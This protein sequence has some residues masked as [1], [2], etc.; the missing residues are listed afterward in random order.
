MNANRH[1]CDEQGM[2]MVLCLMGLY[3]HAYGI[4]HALALYAMFLHAFLFT[5]FKP[6]LNLINQINDSFIFSFFKVCIFN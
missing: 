6:F 4:M 1:N 3:E 5:C 2:G